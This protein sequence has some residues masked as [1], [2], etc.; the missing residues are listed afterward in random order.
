M[1][2]LSYVESSFERAA[3]APGLWHLVHTLSR[4]EKALSQTLSAKSIAHYLPLANVVRTYGGRK[5]PVELPL[6][7]GYVFIKGNLDEVYAADRTKRVA[8][9][10]RVVD[11]QKIASELLS[12]SIALD[13]RISLDPYPYLHVGVK[14]E[15]RCGPLAGMRGIIESKMKRDRLILQV[16]V[17]GQATSLE[18]DGAILDVIS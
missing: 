2:L 16:D 3:A 14:V 1:E 9:I 4:Q 5:V 12:L 17:L 8:G 10:I 11:Q 7:P 15:V 18:I 6:F 13:N